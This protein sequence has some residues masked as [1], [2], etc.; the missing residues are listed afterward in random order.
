MYTFSFNIGH[1]DFLRT[2]KK[3]NNTISS[4]D[5]LLPALGYSS[6]GCM[7]N[8]TPLKDIPVYVIQTWVGTLILSSAEPLSRTSVFIVKSVTVVFSR[9]SMSLWTLS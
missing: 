1:L 6:I 5:H 3:N 2:D 4:T 7:K 9:T 8:A